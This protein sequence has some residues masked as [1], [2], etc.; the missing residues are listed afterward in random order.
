MDRVPSLEL[1]VPGSISSS[2]KHIVFG[3]TLGTG[4]VNFYMGHVGAIKESPK[5]AP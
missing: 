2:G 4:R 5:D 1:E 3:D